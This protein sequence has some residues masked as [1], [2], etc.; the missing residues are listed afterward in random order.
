MVVEAA[1]VDEAAEDAQV[2]EI[3]WETEMAGLPS[4]VEA[5]GLVQVAKEMKLNWMELVADTSAVSQPGW[6]ADVVMVEMVL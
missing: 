4:F 6:F 5:A 2:V 1:V 3:I